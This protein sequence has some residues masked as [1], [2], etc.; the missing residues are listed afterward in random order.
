MVDQVPYLHFL[1]PIYEKSFFEKIVSDLIFTAPLPLR[2]HISF[3]HKRKKRRR[4]DRKK[5]LHMRQYHDH[6]QDN[7]EEPVKSHFAL[8]SIKSQSLLLI[9]YSLSI[10]LGAD[11]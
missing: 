9:K 10:M 2:K 4:K 6:D 7:S 1:P 5:F 8:L 11:E 3:I